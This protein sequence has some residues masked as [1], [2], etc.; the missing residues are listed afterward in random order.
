MGSLFSGVVANILDRPMIVANILETCQYTTTL[1]KSILKENLFM[2]P[3]Y[4]WN[5]DE[6]GIQINNEPAAKGSKNVHVV[7]SVEKG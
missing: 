3:C 2:K 1:L 5:C 6:I 4:I 7:T